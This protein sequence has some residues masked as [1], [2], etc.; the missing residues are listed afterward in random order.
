MNKLLSLIFYLFISLNINGQVDIGDFLMN[1]KAPDCQTIYF[2]LTSLIPDYYE[3]G[4]IDSIYMVLD[5]F[6]E[7][8]SDNELSQRFKILLSIDNNSFNESIYDGTIIN[9]LLLYEEIIAY[10]SRKNLENEYTFED[11]YNQRLLLGFTQEFAGNLLKRKQYITPLEKFFLDF[12]ADQIK[13]FKILKSSDFAG[14]DIQKYYE[15]ELDEY[16][17]QSA[18]I[19]SLISGVWIPQNNLSILG[20]H[21]YIGFGF[22]GKIKS[23]W[24][25]LSFNYKFVDSPNSYQVILNDSLRTT[26]NFYGTYVG[27]DVGYQFFVFKNN[28]FDLI[29][30]VASDGFTAIYINIP[31]SDDNIRKRLESLNLNIGLGYKYFFNA[32][33]YLG[34]D[35]KYN[36]VDFEN[37]GGTDLSG[38]VITI[39]LKF[40]FL[41][42]IPYSITEKKYLK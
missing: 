2:N 7:K 4:E 5:Y 12:Y 17:K 6:E 30:G 33:R 42:K 11:P 8:C 10:W 27:L 41:G 32:R 25:E 20:P 13:S 38:N 37:P 35:I 19:F 29:G 34:L 3:R 24:F 1:R 40:G 22:G 18:I 28:S 39:S 15:I 26:N 16:F 31:D 14:T 36:F 23:F 9:N 21:P